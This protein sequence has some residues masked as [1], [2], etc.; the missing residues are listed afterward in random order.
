MAETHQY[1]SSL[2]AVQDLVVAL[3]VAKES[4]PNPVIV[5]RSRILQSTLAAIRRPNFSYSRLIEVEFVGEDAQD[6]GGPR[7]EFMRYCYCYPNVTVKYW[8]VHICA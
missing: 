6:Y 4:N 8:T 7:R 5:H 2:D 3:V 1:E